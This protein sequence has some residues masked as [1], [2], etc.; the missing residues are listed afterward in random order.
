MQ[1]IYY[2]PSE[3][4]WWWFFLQVPV[5]FIYQDYT[6]Y[7]THRFY[8]TPFMYKHFHKLHHTYKQPTAFS[9]TAIHPVEIMQVQLTMLVPIFVIPVH[10]AMFYAIALYT[11]Y[12]GIIDHSGVTFKALWW[13]PWQP[14]AIF[15]DNHHQYFHVNFGFNIYIW[16]V[17]HGTYRKKDRVYTED[18]YYGK[19]LAFDEVSKDVLVNDIA[20]RKSEN[21]LA[22]TDNV[23][24][25]DLDLSDI[26]VKVNTK[27]KT[28]NK[29]H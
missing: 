9:V 11:Y 5:I 19:G 2:S 29:R 28:K 10:W 21:P 4:G 13:Q 16:D 15:H 20:E 1:W 14:D 27:T 18:I 8:H 24:V 26:N 22:Y 7:L 23:N 6:T 12:H 3:Y 17:L 25:N